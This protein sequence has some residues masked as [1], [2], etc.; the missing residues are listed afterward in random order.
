MKTERPVPFSTRVLAGLCL[1][2]HRNT[3]GSNR[4]SC[5]EAVFQIF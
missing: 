1:P 2:K 4:T 3:I 5:A